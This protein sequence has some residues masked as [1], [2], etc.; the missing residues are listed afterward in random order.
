MRPLSLRWRLMLA[1]GAAILLALGLATVGL[2]LLFDRHVERVAVA[3]LGARADTLVAM[4][5]PQ[6]SGPPQ[7][8]DP[9]R[10]PL[11]DQPLSGHY[12]QMQLGDRIVRSRSLW[13]HV[14]R[15]DTPPPS[16]GSQRVLTLPDPRGQ[17]LLALQRSLLVGPG[18]DAVPLTLIVATERAT[19][20]EAR[21]G[22]FTDLL[23]YVTALALLLLAAFWAQ[24][25]VG[26]RPLSRMAERVGDLVQGRRARIGGDLP[27]EVMP[28]AAQLDR[29]MDDRDREMDRARHRAADLAHGFKTPL[30][31]LMGDA[32]QL[33]S[34]GEDEIADSIETVSTAM[35]RLVDRELT[36]ARIRSDRSA[37]AT[38]PAPVVAKIA[39]VLQRMP[40]GAGLDWSLPP[41]PGPRARIEGEDLTEALGALMENAMRHAATR[42]AIRL[43]PEAR[44]VAIIIRDDGP[45]IPPA[46]LSRMMQRGERMDSSGEGQGIGL[47]LVSDI[48]EAAGGTLTLENAQP[49][50]NAVLRL[51]RAD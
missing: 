9:P 33:R 50:L 15:D 17:P 51:P 35:Q 16:P 44:D 18:A 36:R 48:A 7:L 6:Q 24:I 10:D 19:L 42:I 41:C 46:L 2:A 27:A 28:L 47:A 45:G 3:D 21:R 49:G 4:V 22:F 26:L 20:A 31:A 5:E 14:L 13:D 34:R 25:V 11:Y 12:W 37:E 8:R 38:D 23:P 40:G 39:S 43:V 32:G 30:Q 29:M 1:G